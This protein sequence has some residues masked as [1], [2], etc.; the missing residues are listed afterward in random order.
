MTIGKVYQ[1]TNYD[2]FKLLFDNRHLN[3]AHLKRLK[4]SIQEGYIPVPIIVN[5][6]NELIEGQHRWYV[7]REMQIPLAYT[8]IKGLTIKDAQRLNSTIRTW[9]ADDYIESYSKNGNETYVKYLEFKNNTG[10]G[11]NEC[12]ALLSGSSHGKEIQHKFNSGKF[13]I[14]DEQFAY[15]INQKLEQIQSSCPSF[16]HAK[17]RSFVL[18]ISKLLERDN[19]NFDE[20]VHK[21]K[22]QPSSLVKCTNVMS[23]R[24]LIEE[25]YNYKRR[26]KVSLKY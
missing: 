20:F 6:K 19:F 11:H 2:Q 15:G 8:V 18:A 9:N 22:I 23:Y 16:K 7:C 26:E 21:V 3:Q 17:S 10:L 14:K 13:V 24:Q 12:Q 5:E 25:I 4:K 1:T